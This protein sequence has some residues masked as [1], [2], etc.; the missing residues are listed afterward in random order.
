VTY[1]RNPRVPNV[2]ESDG[3]YNGK[4]KAVDGSLHDSANEA[5]K[6][7]RKAMKHT[8]EGDAMTDLAEA[9]RNLLEACYQADAQ[10]ELPES[11][12]GELLDAVRAGLINSAYSDVVNGECRRCG[13]YWPGPNHAK[14]L[15]WRWHK[16][17]CVY[18]KLQEKL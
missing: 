18:F 11:V 9:A 17:R 14:L 12:S 6:Y 3:E 5:D 7:D 2:W 8:K 10:E 16:P 15:E 1:I 4:Y 13:A